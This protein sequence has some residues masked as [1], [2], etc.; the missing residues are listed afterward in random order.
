MVRRPVVEAQAVRVPVVRVAG[1][2]VARLLQRTRPL[3]V[4]VRREAQAAH[5]GG[6]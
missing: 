5:R 6:R 3:P 2:R 1:L 4:A